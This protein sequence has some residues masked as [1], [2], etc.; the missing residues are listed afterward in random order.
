VS[1]DVCDP[2]TFVAGCSWSFS[3]GR[4]CSFF[5]IAGENS[6][7]VNHK[8]LQITY[9]AAVISREENAETRF[10]ECL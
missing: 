3:W 6:Q 8:V 9:P 7:P 4:V 5:V 2:S 1:N 10:V